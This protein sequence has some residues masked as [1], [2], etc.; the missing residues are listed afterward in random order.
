MTHKIDVMN[1]YITIYYVACQSD[2]AQQTVSSTAPIIQLNL[3]A[4]E[5]KLHTVHRVS[6]PL[7][8]L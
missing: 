6:A 8:L 3:S 1:F 5:R 4:S 2:A 7:L